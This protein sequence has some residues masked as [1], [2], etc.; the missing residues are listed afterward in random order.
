MPT[1][2]FTW[3]GGSGFSW[4][5]IHHSFN[6]LDTVL[7]PWQKMNSQLMSAGGGGET[8]CIDYLLAGTHT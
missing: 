8:G 1:H 6:F 5:I 4:K 2:N 3:Q 7:Y